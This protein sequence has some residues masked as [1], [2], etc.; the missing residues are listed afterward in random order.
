MN[1]LI[2]ETPNDS[3]QASC[4]I[5]NPN[6]I[7]IESD[8]CG[9]VTSIGEVSFPSGHFPPQ[10]SIPSPPRKELYSFNP[11]GKHFWSKSLDK[12]FSN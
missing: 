4:S 1:I 9:I 12:T 7:V 11:N 8:L 2:P 3:S 6:A 10:T 5:V